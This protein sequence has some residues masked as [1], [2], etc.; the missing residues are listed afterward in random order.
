MG[1][2]LIIAVIGCVIVLCGFG[3]KSAFAALP[4]S[5]AEA[6]GTGAELYQEEDFSAAA[7]EFR[8]AYEISKR[9]SDGPY[10][11]FLFNAARASHQGGNTRQAYVYYERALE[12]EGPN[13]LGEEERG[14]AQG[15]LDGLGV[16]FVAEG[17]AASVAEQMPMIEEVRWGGWGW[18]GVGLA[19][20]GVLLLGVAGALSSRASSQIDALEGVEDI[21]IYE[22][23][24]RD[25]EG[26]QRLGR[27]LLYGGGGL[28]LVGAGVMAWELLTTDTQ[29][30]P[31]VNVM[32][33]RDGVVATWEVRFE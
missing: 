15:Y 12:V 17:T 24:K 26:G 28:V 2:R 11:V 29:E 3:V 23:E 5:A 8:R 16:T 13:A 18:S 25:I 9:A 6:M 7:V 4:D 32:P 1:Y 19:G 10:A 30:V 21:S 20:T 27:G 31:R 14:R 22:E 33:T